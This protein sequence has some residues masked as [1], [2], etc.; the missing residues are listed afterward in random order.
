MVVIVPVLN[1]VA[2]SVSIT[3]DMARA[4]VQTR[5]FSG[6]KVHSEVLFVGAGAMAVCDFAPATG[7]L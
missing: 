7:T 6:L 4:R 3:T 2:L 5:I 1:F